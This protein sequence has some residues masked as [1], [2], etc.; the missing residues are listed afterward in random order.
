VLT[1]SETADVL[2]RAPDGWD[3]RVLDVAST[4]VLAVPS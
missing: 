3:A 1:V 2:A 4:G